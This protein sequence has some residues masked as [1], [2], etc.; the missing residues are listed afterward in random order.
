MGAQCLVH[1][2]ARLSESSMLALPGGSAMFGPSRGK[3]GAQ[4]LVHL[5]A[6][7]LRRRM[8]INFAC[9]FCSIL[10]ERNVLFISGQ[11]VS[12]VVQLGRARLPKLAS[13]NSRIVQ[14]GR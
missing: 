1:L 9:S 12:V 11:D 3:V 2:G 14:L 4:R 5:G 7:R 6:R 8:L 13:F 10:I